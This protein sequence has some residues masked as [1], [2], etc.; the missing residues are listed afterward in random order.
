MADD[1]GI[2]QEMLIEPTHKKL[3]IVDGH[4]VKDVEDYQNPELLYKSLIER[5]RK[6][7]PSADVS[8]IE[9]AYHIARDAHKGQTRKSGE[10][11][12]IHPLWVGTVSYTHLTLPTICSV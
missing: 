1:I 9:K 3:E 7:H 6:Y 10:E 11:Y 4:A 5:V 2:Q 12:I 8:M